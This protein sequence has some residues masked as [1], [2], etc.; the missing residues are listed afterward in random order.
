MI[1]IKLEE[2]YDDYERERVNREDR[3]KGVGSSR[4]FKLPLRERF[5]MPENTECLGPQNQDFAGF[6]FIIVC[7]SLPYNLSF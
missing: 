2:N 6:L 4:K 7:I 3:R 1:F 5:L